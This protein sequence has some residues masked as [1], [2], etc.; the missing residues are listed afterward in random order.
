[1]GW[2]TSISSVSMIAVDSDC[3]GVVAMDV[4]YETTDAE[5]PRE[6]SGVTDDEAAHTEGGAGVIAVYLSISA[7]VSTWS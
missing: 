1:M 6:D 5:R 3:D 4:P 2:R 7:R